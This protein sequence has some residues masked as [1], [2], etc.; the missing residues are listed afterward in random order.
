MVALERFELSLCD[1]R[2]VVDYPVADRATSKNGRGGESRNPNLP[3]PKRK[4]CL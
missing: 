4:L 3:L 2:S 1:V